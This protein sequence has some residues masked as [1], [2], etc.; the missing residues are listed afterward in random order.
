MLIRWRH[1]LRSEGLGWLVEVEGDGDGQGKVVKQANHEVLLH[2]MNW[3]NE[4]AYA[5]GS[6]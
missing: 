3:C 4:Q 5:S 6:M 1:W 2:A